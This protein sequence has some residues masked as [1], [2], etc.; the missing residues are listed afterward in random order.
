[1]F[2]FMCSL[3]IWHEQLISLRQRQQKTGRLYNDLKKKKHNYWNR[4][5]LI[6]VTGNRSVTWSDGGFTISILKIPFCPHHQIGKSWF[7][8]V[9]VFCYLFW[10]N[11]KYVHLT[12]NIL[13]IDIWHTSCPC[14]SVLTRYNINYC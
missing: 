6:S 11:T 1:M 13:F 2:L 3:W 7:S 9:P 10:N 8:V 5:E 12:W 14:V 4:S